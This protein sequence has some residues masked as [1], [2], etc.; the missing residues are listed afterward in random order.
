MYVPLVITI[1]TE[2][3]GPIPHA[4][5]PTTIILNSSDS[6]INT[7]TVSLIILPISHVDSL[8]L[9]IHRSVAIK[10]AIRNVASIFD[11]STRHQFQGFSN[12]HWINASNDLYCRWPNVDVIEGATEVISRT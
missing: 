3:S 5:S 11:R 9:P 10:P 8:V 4:L 2:I 6:P 7:K 1:Q 12:F